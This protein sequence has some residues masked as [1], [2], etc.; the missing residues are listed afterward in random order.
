MV[1]ELT[2]KK[3]TNFAFA[4]ALTLTGS[5]AICPVRCFWAASISPLLIRRTDQ[6]VE[7]TT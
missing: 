5:V 6:L 7:I 4:H 3:G 2:S 1:P